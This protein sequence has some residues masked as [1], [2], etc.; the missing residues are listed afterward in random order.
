MIILNLYC[1]FDDTV[2]LW[3]LEDH[4]R[5]LWIILRGIKHPTRNSTR[6]GGGGSSTLATSWTFARSGRELYL[7]RKQC[8]KA[9]SCQISNPA[10]TDRVL[11][12][13]KSANF[14]QYSVF[15]FWFAH[16]VFLL[17]IRPR[18]LKEFRLLQPSINDRD[19]SRYDVHN[20]SSDILLI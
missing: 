16:T 13:R 11:V 6:N 12:D 14:L 8:L 20:T 10:A 18:Y 1:T 19:Y 4:I 2:T 15:S 9:I 7:F 17:C 5:A 3:F